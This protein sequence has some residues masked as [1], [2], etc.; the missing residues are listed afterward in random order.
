MSVE[1]SAGSRALSAHD[2]DRMRMAC[3]VG[4]RHCGFQADRFRP[5]TS[6]AHYDAVPEYGDHAAA[7]MASLRIGQS[8]H[9]QSTR[10]PL[11]RMPLTSPVTAKQLRISDSES[12]IAV[13]EL[14]TSDS[15]YD[16]DIV[17]ST[18]STYDG[19]AVLRHPPTPMARR[20]WPAHQSARP[21]DRLI[22]VDTKNRR[23]GP[24]RARNDGCSLVISL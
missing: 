19:R 7:G 16:I 1:R 3:R 23:F 12:E 22:S 9:R 13:T 4:N 20:T 2:D 21:I 10:G 24:L 8:R 14:R 6:L 15:K 17:Y 5:N 18:S 11:L